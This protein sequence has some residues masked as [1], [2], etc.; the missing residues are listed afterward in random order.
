VFKKRVCML[1]SVQHPFEVRL[2]HREAKTLAEAGYSVTII[3]QYDGMKVVDG[4]RIIGIGRARNRFFRMLRTIKIFMRAL[5]ERADIYQVQYPELLLWGVLLKLFTRRP[6]IYDVH[7]DFPGAVK[8]PNWIPRYLRGPLSHAVDLYERTLAKFVT[9]VTTA[10]EQISKRFRHHEKVVT[11]FNFP[12]L[13][14]LENI[15]NAEKPANL[16]KTVIHPGSLSSERGDDVMLDAFK[17]VRDTI[18]EARLL[19][20]GD[21]T[22]P[23]G[24]KLKRKVAEYGLEDNVTLVEYLPHDHVLEYIAKSTVGLSLLQPV[25]KFMKNI[26]QKVFEYMACGIPSVVSDLPPIRPFIEA[27]QAGILVPPS[28][29]KKIAEAVIFLLQHPEDARKMG[30]NGR[31]AVLEKYNWEKEA[32][33]HLI[34]Y[35]EAHGE[36]R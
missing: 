5:A 10:D 8:I 1:V 19:L 30:E 33:K 28:D 18:R 22:T 35:R 2:F 6:V 17:I 16:V 14:Y 26:P 7:E 25:P 29:P 23:Y 3:A 4:I 31:Q 32:N 34:L 12:R 11:L 24:A 9:Y 27:S 13:A 36:N 20:I 15:V 21:F